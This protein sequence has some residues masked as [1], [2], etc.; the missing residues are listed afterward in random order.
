MNEDKRYKWAC[1]VSHKEEAETKYRESSQTNGSH[2]NRVCPAN[3]KSDVISPTQT[4]T[5]QLRSVA[6]NQNPKIRSQKKNPD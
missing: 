6:E 2:L 4:T 1:V 5:I 3:Q